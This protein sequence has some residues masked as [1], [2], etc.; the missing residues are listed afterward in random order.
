MASPDA[1]GLA[2]KLGHKNVYVFSDGLPAWVRAGRP[3]GTIEK[4]PKADIKSIPASELKTM[5]DK[6][7]DFVL[8]DI[9]FGRL[10]RKYKIN[11]RGRK[12]IPLDMLIERH[13]ELDPGKKI[14]IIGE[15]GNRSGIAARYLKTKGFDNIVHV[16]GGMQAWVGEGY[17]AGK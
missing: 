11:Y 15:T 1:A 13:R 7:K 5:V 17:S 10:A 16:K 6:G 9:R 2:V 14:V 4:L 3:T 8:L 12:N